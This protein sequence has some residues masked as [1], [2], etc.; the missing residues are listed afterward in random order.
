MTNTSITDQQLIDMLN[1][2]AQRDQGFRLLMRQY[3]RCLYWHVRRIVIDHDDAEDVLQETAIKVL[4]SVSKFKGD[5]QLGTWLYR[6]ATN[7]ALMHLRRQTRLFQ[8][9]DTLGP[10][11][12]ERLV[13]Q[14]DLV[15]DEAAMLFQRAIL[16]L[17]TQQ[18]VAFNLRYY[19]ELSYEQIAQVTGKSVATL[20]SNYHYAVKKIENYL[21]E[22]SL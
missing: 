12:A 15:G 7:E 5:S 17:P 22:H 2:H 16:Q 9:I 19:D 14:P 18:R 21:K 1:N 13:S 4:E 11:L 8:S 10:E 20:K 6:I 3:G